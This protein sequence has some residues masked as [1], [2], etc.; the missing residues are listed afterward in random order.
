M[1][2]IKLFSDTL[3]GDGAFGCVYRAVAYGLNGSETTV[4]A[5]KMTRGKL[6]Y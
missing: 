2:V 5:V 1:G 6:T 4:V 3:L